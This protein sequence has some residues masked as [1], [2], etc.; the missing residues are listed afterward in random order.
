MTYICLC[1]VVSHDGAQHFWRKKV[2][3][4]VLVKPLGT[5]GNNIS[6]L[7]KNNIENRAT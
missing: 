1:A 5:P 4:V 2:K 7:K 3:W 6:K